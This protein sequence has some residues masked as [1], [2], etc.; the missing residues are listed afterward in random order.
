MN[1]FERMSESPLNVLAVAGSLHRKS[2]TRIVINHVAEKL[3]A[4]GCSVD[5]LDL[6]TLQSGHV[7]RHAGV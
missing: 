4:D 7:I 3:R 6:Q 5:V 1:Y 2:V